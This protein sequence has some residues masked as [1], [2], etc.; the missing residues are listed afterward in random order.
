[1]KF[2]RNH[3]IRRWWCV[4]WTTSIKDNRWKES[5]MCYFQLLL[6]KYNR[7]VLFTGDIIW[8]RRQWWDLIFLFFPRVT[9]AYEVDIGSSKERCF[10]Y[11]KPICPF[12]FSSHFLLL[13]SYIHFASSYSIERWE[14]EERDRKKKKKLVVWSNLVVFNWLR[15]WTRRRFAGHSHHFLLLLLLRLH[16]FHFFP[17]GWHIIYFHHGRCSLRCYV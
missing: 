13:L 16:S 9:K 10:M 11:L 5:A 2:N 3:N 7:F 12:C 15:H 17:L 6:D 8:P 14:P 4:Y 1:M